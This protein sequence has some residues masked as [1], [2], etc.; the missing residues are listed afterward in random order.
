[1]LAAT[2][3]KALW[4]ATRATGMVC[5]VLLTLSVALGVAE[6]VRF[7]SPRWPRFVVAAVHRNASL[8]AVAFLGVHIVTAV[9]D[10][11]APIRIIDAFVPFVGSYRPIWLGLGTVASDLLL[12]LVI[13]S[14]LRERIGYPIWRAM[15]WAAYAAWPVALVHGLGTGSDTR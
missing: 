8:L 11:F 4:Y 15:H 10:S 9:A 6:V 13:T 3:S 2:S 12:A 14:L 5:L 1:M 7:A